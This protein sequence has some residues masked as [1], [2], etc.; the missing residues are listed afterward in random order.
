MVPALILYVENSPDDVELAKLIFRQL[1]VANPLQVVRSGAEAL[2]Y[3]L[4][5][6]QFT[7]RMKYPFPGVVWLDIAMPEQDGFEV[8]ANIRET[9]GLRDLPVFMFSNFD[10][11]EDHERAKQL[12]ANGYMAKAASY[13]SFAAWLGDLNARLQAADH[14]EAAI[15]FSRE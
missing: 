15:F 7:D 13:Q 10:E 4:G 11:P 6:G 1:K 12:G 9:D 3:L 2:D 8:L 14:P 5:R